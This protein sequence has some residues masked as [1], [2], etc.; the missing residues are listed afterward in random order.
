MSLL[1]RH[2]ISRNR[3]RVFRHFEKKTFTFYLLY[4]FNYIEDSGKGFYVSSIHSR[5]MYVVSMERAG[6]DDSNHTKYLN[7]PKIDLQGFRNK[8]TIS[9]KLRHTCITGGGRLLCLLNTN[10]VSLACLGITN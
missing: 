2:L 6:K 5:I 8:A 4:F 10:M 9:K 1:L 7:R 3:E